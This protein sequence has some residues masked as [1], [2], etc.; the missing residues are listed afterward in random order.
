MQCGFFE[1]DITPAF[2]SIIPGDFGARRCNEI[3]DPLFVRAMACSSGKESA[4]IA[5]IDACGIYG[6]D[7][8]KIVK[9]VTECIPI[10]AENIM[11]MATHTH[12][13]GPTLNWG[14]EVIADPAYMDMLI[15]KTA[16]AIVS[17]WNKKEESELYLGKELLDDISFI[18]VFKMKDGSLKTN[19]GYQNAHLIDEPTTTIDPDVF[20][21]G[22]KQNGKFAGAIVNFA[23]HPAVVY[24]RQISGD[25]ISI[26]SNEMKALYGDD[27]I[28]LFVNGA[29][30]NINHV[31]PFQPE[32]Y[33]EGRH[34]YM[35]KR[36]AETVHQALNTAEPIDSEIKSA[37]DTVT[38]RYRKPSD[39][40]L[41]AA[42]RHMDSLGD[43][44]IH[45]T[46]LE[47]PEYMET[48]FA[49][50]TLNI[51]ADKHTV[52][53]IFLQILKIGP[54]ALFAI[55]CQMFVQFGKKVKNACC[56]TAFVA[57]FA[58]DYCGY[59]PTAECMKDGV[60]EARLATS[61]ALEAAAGE[62]VTD[63]AIAL[64]EKM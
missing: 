25:F 15:A 29:C 43:N 44:L 47:D 54:V 37:T 11:I 62:I 33:E 49:M 24:T 12:S 3:L 50:Q 9:R 7:V 26:L 42:K 36:L 56:D 41:L 13:G 38:V 22:A 59:V 63:A 51:Q 64:Y 60:Y 4:A 32:T 39:E 31:N 20:V 14:E 61:S 35:G 48:F 58:N 18:R 17:A 6:E 34:I 1:C 27:F 19:P 46:Y 5:V 53:P 28:T 40:Q 45:S 30:G 57:I 55:P 8:C 21:L 10:P 52:R 16:D 2:G 23:C